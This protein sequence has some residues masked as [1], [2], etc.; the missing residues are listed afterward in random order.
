MN[1][2]DHRTPY[3]GDHGIRFEPIDQRQAEETPAADESRQAGCKRR[4]VA[5]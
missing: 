2:H 1:K 4:R 3:S 5:R